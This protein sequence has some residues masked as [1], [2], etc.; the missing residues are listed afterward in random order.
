MADNFIAG[1]PPGI[2]FAAAACAYYQVGLLRTGQITGISIVLF[3]LYLYVFD[4]SNQ[5]RSEAEDHE[6]KPYR[7]IPSGL[8]TTKG[9]LRRFWCAMAIYSAVGFA[10]GTLAWVLLW[11]AVVIVLNLFVPPRYYLQLKQVAMSLGIVA[12]LAAAWQLVGPLNRTGWTWILVLML[13]VSLVMR[14][15]DVR[16]IEGDRRIGRRTIPMVIGHWPVRIWFAL[17]YTAVPVV[18]HIMLFAPRHPGRLALAVC[19]AAMLAL[20]WSA[21]LMVLLFRTRRADR[22]SYQLYCASYCLALLCGIVV[23]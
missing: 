17:V 8:T 20:C 22:T 4:T 6:N 15:E 18:L 9:L 1:T 16:D 7:P 13:C 12:Q 3:S 14:F 21:A 2:L 19:D 5:A 23:L 11:Q 10:T